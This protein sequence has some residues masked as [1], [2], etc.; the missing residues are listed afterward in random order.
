MASTREQPCNG[1]HQKNTNT[2][3]KIVTIGNGKC[4]DLL[5]QPKLIHTEIQRW[6]NSL[7]TVFFSIMK[8]SK[9]LPK[10][11]CI[12]KYPFTVLSCSS[13]INYMDS[14]G[15]AFAKAWRFV[16]LQSQNASD[17]ACFDHAN[18]QIWVHIWGPVVTSVYHIIVIIKISRKISHTGQGF[19]KQ[20]IFF[21]EQQLKHAPKW[22]EH[23]HFEHCPGAYNLTRRLY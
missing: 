12:G 10:Q 22:R 3:A 19:P 5:I 18:Q 15:L 7:V 1:T 2:K 14:S 4:S 9:T 8:F 11:R 6:S 20:A 23:L 21:S 13:L 16:D 17:N